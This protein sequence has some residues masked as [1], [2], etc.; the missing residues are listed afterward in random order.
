MFDTSHKEKQIAIYQK[1]IF[2]MIQ[3]H[4]D[5]FVSSKIVMSEFEKSVKNLF[6]CQASAIGL[7]PP[8]TSPLSS[9]G[10]SD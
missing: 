3:N 5:L 8:K 1:M 10:A 9:W 4:F 2:R 7:G 6:H